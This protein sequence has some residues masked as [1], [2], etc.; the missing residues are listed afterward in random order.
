MRTCKKEIKK[1]SAL[2]L[3]IFFFGQYFIMQRG[4]HDSN[5][6]PLEHMTISL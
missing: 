1:V 5:I 2:T 3:D 4:L 6:N